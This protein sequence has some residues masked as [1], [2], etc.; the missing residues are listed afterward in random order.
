[1]KIKY[2]IIFLFTLAFS[3]GCIK[4]NQKTVFVK[5]NDKA[6]LDT[7]TLKYCFPLNNSFSVPEIT[8]KHSTNYYYQNIIFFVSYCGAIDTI[9]IDLAHKN[10]A[11]KGKGAGQ[12]R[13]H[14]QELK[15]S[16]I[17][18]KDMVNIKVWH[19]MRDRKTLQI[20]K[21]SEVFAVGIKLNEND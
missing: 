6:W 16:A 5:T 20:K 15:R 14:T 8:I 12:V 4:D 9:N 21:V 17:N 10:G 2:N 11:W 7:D 3:V 18:C 1:M 13:Y 19:S